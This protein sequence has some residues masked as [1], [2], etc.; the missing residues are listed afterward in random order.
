M[1]TNQYTYNG[2]GQRAQIVDSQGTKKPIWDVE[3]IL[4]ETDGSDVTQVVYTQEPAGYGNLVSQRRD[5]TTST[6]LFDAL[7][8]TRKLTNSAGAVTD[9]Y[10]FRGY[11]QSRLSSGTTV[12]V[13]RWT[14]EPGYYYDT[15][16]SAYHL[17]ARPY[18]PTLARFLN[19][20]PIGFQGSQW[21]LYE[22]VG[23]N[24]PNAVDSSGLFLGWNYG[25][26]CGWSKRGPGAPIDALD[27]CCQ[28]HD[29]CQDTWWTCNP[30]HIIKCSIDLCECAKKAESTG[31]TTAACKNAAKWVQILFCTVGNPFDTDHDFLR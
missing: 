7:G 12:N 4:L 30:Y 24:P 20:D 28:D 16:R 9:S 21:N 1:I 26:Y 22:Y 10:E 15:D 25:S 14:G 31:C 5:T 3:N 23:S 6:Y 19:P 18:S 11:G 2:D 13:F 27:S 29:N 17:R 8:S